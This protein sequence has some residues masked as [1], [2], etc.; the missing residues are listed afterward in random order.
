MFE[1]AAVSQI[2]ATCNHTECKG[3]GTYT[4]TGTCNNCGSRWGVTITKGH[5]APMRADCPR[6]G[7]A[8]V[9]CYPESFI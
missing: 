6:C 7:C 9:A 1:S 8:R 5:D 4:M 2:D 3:K